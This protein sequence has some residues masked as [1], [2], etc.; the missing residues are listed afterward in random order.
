ME[1]PR[2]RCEARGEDRPHQATCARQSVLP[3]RGTRIFTSVIARALTLVG[4]W[5]GPISA[6]ALTRCKSSAMPTT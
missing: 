3:Q 2:S 6:A 5:P 1:P 4:G